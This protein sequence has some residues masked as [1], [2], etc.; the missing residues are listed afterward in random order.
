VQGKPVMDTHTGEMV[1]AFEEKAAVVIVDIHIF[2]TSYPVVEACK[3]LDLP[4]PKIMTFVP[5]STA[6][7]SW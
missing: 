6:G 4:L 5:L 7:Y 3:D 1:Y 2:A